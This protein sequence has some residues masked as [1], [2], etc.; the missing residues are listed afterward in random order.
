MDSGSMRDSET[1]SIGD[2]EIY[3]PSEEGI[4]FVRVNDFW[5]ELDDNRG[6]YA[7]TVNRNE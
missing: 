3:S 2:K 4:L 6:E 1:I 7:I 5:S